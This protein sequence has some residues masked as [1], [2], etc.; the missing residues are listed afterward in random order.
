MV[1]PGLPG[2][3]PLSFHRRSLSALRRLG[4]PAIA[5]G[6]LAALTALAAAERVRAQSLLVQVRE[7]NGS[8]PLPGALVTLQR[9]DGSVLRRALTDVRGQRFFGGV[10]PGPVVVRAEMVGRKTVVS[11][12]FSV[13]EDETVQ[14]VLSLP[15]L[16]FGIDRT[17]VEAEGR[18]RLHPGEELAAARIWEEVRKAITA[19]AWSEDQK[20]YAYALRGYERQVGAA[21]NTVEY[22]TTRARLLMTHNPI[23]SLPPDSLTE[24]GYVRLLD[25][26][27]VDYFAPDAAALLARDFL[28]THC[29]RVEGDDAESDLIGVRFEP[30]RENGPPDIAGVFWLEP[31]T[32]RLRR[33]DFRY[34]STPWRVADRRIGGE[35]RFETLPDGTWIVRRWAI[36]MPILQRDL[37]TRGGSAGEDRDRLVALREVGQEITAVQAADGSVVR[38]FPGTSVAGT[39]YD[40]TRAAPLA[41]ARVML[42]GTEY[43][44]VTDSMGTFLI[45]GV[46]GGRYALTFAH[47]RL[48]SL[49]AVLPPRPITVAD[50]RPT[51]V[52]VAVPSTNTLWAAECPGLADRGVVLGTV[53]DETSG[54]ELPGVHIQVRVSGQE[55]DP[56]RTTTD[57]RGRYVVCSVPAGA[58]LRVSAAISG[59]SSAVVE[60]RVRPG[61]WAAI[62]LLVPM[63]DLAP[64][65]APARDAA[66][67]LIRGRVRDAETENVI[68][69]ADVAVMSV[70]GDTVAHTFSSQDGTFRVSV[71]DGSRYQVGANALGYADLPPGLVDVD[72]GQIVDL[73]VRLSKRAIPL[74]ALVVTVERR[75]LA[76]D[77]TGFYDRRAVG[78]GTFVTPEQVEK[79][80]PEFVS[81][82]F[83]TVPSAVLVEDDFGH[84]DV[85][86][87]GNGGG[88]WPR[89]VVDGVVVSLGGGQEKPGM[90]YILGGRDLEAIEIY[91]RPAQVPPQYGGAGSACG[92]IVIWTKH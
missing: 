80:D 13:A 8:R 11:D 42:S 90:D 88:C 55:A 72:R 66:R 19:T 6:A 78:L 86:F 65:P 22:D 38:S 48:D 53:R 37:P 2:G 59:L 21:T 10:G 40:S 46:P 50:G 52:R 4:L 16:P 45:G 43:G 14:Q 60:T 41:G 28:D 7:E 82:M 83:V 31:G 57:A 17:E 36:R 56:I 91:K 54:T 26:G 24:G 71:P 3:L 64:A 84:R 75:N 33:L 20:L 18:C 67:A 69:M 87:R 89:V 76:L 62:P 30:V 63:S 77:R 9:P 73:D 29:L 12:S 74:E 81:D 5:V 1:S 51:R 35:V 68:P 58:P 79:R 70:N 15:P 61:A 39:V 92:V 32:A 49:R 44:A 25:S 23:R 34:T 27:D 85:Y 47:P